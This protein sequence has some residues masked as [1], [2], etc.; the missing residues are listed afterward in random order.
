MRAGPKAALL[1][2][3]YLSDLQALSG[4]SPAKMS[5]GNREAPAWQVKDQGLIVAW[6]TDKNVFI[7]AAGKP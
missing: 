1:H 6:F 3:K 2:A 7:L 5:M 4:V